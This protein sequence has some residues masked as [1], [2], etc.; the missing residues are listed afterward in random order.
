MNPRNKKSHVSHHRTPFGILPSHEPKSHRPIAK[1]CCNNE[2]RLTKHSKNA[3]TGHLLST[4]FSHRQ[5][6][7][8]RGQQKRGSKKRKKK[9]CGRWNPWFRGINR[10]VVTDTSLLLRDRLV[11]QSARRLASHNAL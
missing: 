10:A 1:Q 7:R 5:S 6:N 11:M 3:Q 2:I 9:G 8:D 4:M